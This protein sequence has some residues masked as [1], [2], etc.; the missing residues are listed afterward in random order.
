MNPS[1]VIVSPV[2]RSIEV[3]D[4]RTSRLFYH[5]VLGFE[6]TEDDHS[7]QAVS[8]PA[9]LQ[10][11]APG[12]SPGNSAMVFFETNDVAAM[13]GAIRDR[14]GDPS[15]IEKVN[16]IKMRMFA[17]RDPDGHTLWF[18]Q[19]YDVPVKP[20]PP[21]GL[22]M[23]LPELPLNNVSEGVVHYRDVLGFRINYQQ[24]DLA[25]MYRDQVSLLLIAR[26]ERH[27]GI[28][29][30]Y[31]YVE[32]ADALFAELRAKG[33]NVQGEPVSQPWGLREFLVLDPEGN[34]IRFGQTFE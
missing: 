15:E 34:Q 7:I 14:G 1:P 13:H 3:R 16:W 30:T 33:A 27:K 5:D 12:N 20:V 26:T 24:H 25:V 17:V 2:S 22:L 18:G 9:R 29:S 10:L 21:Q 28:G 23:I 11:G 32:N 31:V 8:G 19:S 4:P 6:I